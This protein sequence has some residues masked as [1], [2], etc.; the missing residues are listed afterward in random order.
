[1][2]FTKILAMILAVV[3]AAS[4][5]FACGGKTNED[6]KGEVVTDEN[7]NVIEDTTE[8]VVGEGEMAVTVQITTDEFEQP[9][10]EGITVVNV[11]ATV[12]D[13][14][15]AFCK[16]EGIECVYEETEDGEDPT[17]VDALGNYK[18][19]P[20]A[21]E[22]SEK[23]IYYWQVL[24]NDVELAG[25]ASA[26]EASADDVIR[27]NYTSIPNGPWVMVRFENE[28]E[29][30]VEDTMVVYD[31]GDTVLNAAADALKASGLEYAMTEHGV[32]SVEKLL[33]K[34]TP[35]YDDIWEVTVDKTAYAADT[36]IDT[37]ALAEEQVIVFNFRRVEK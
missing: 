5:L 27:Y 11:G 28:G 32:Q 24:V 1:M 31:D 17:T 19:T 9:L 30:V 6:E 37:I 14:I 8:L 13:V 12:L 7:G 26:N 3:L 10:A 25:V 21:K 36:E 35:I 34:K 23:F 20:K 2:K 29:I 16:N 18:S 33:A 22:A 15:T 4:A